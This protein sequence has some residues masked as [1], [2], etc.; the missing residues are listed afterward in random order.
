MISTY[1]GRHFGLCMSIFNMG[2]TLAFGVGPIVIT[3]LVRTHGLQGTLFSMGIGIPLLAVLFFMVPRPQGEGLAA[4]GFI[5]S[6]REALGD[7]WRSVA[8]LWGVMVI[9]AFVSQTFMTFF[10]LLYA[11]EGYSLMAIGWVVSLYTLAGAASGLVAGSLADRFRFKPIFIASFLLTVPAMMLS[12]HLRGDWIYTC[13]FLTG[14]FSMAPLPLGVAMGQRLA[15]KGRSMVSSLMMGL[16]LGIGGL[17]S[18]VVGWLADLY[19][20]QAVLAWLPAA[21]VA[22]ALLSLRIP[23]KK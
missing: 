13:S 17:L 20:I 2:G 14:F 12:L 16:A 18:P 15:P 23:E 7:S 9:R 22:A 4:R 1:A 11:R 19:T 6:L 8:N 5:G 3:Y 10:P 21:P